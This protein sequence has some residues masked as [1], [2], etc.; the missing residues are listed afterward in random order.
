MEDIRDHIISGGFGFNEY[1]Y[2]TFYEVVKSGAARLRKSVP[3]FLITDSLDH[4]E[5]KEQYE[6]CH[7]IKSFFDKNPTRRFSMSREDWLRY[8]W[9]C[10]DK[11]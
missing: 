3:D 8:G 5:K 6:K 9:Q 11:V 1:Y 7:A 4:F 10:A 2:R